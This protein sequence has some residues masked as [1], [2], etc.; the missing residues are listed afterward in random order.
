MTEQGKRRGGR[1]PQTIFVRVSGEEKQRIC[2]QAANSQMSASRFLVCGA[3]AGKPPPTTAERADLERLLRL[4]LRAHRSL[5][6]L[7][8]NTRQMRLAGADPG[9]EEELQEVLNA[10]G[11]LIHRLKE[12]L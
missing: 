8:A 6:R 4:F 12:R 7:L 3:L 9:M 11:A 1:Y 10:L 2:A 5:T